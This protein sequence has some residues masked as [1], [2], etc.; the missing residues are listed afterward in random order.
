MANRIEITITAKKDANLRKIGQQVKEEVTAGAR[1]AGDAIE[2]EIGDGAR[3]AGKRAETELGDAGGRAGGR[4]SRSFSARSQL[5]DAR[6]RFAR[7]GAAAGGAMASAASRSFRSR[8]AGMFGRVGRRIGR[9]FGIHFG[10]AAGDAGQTAGR[11][12]VKGFANI[13][14]GGITSPMLLVPLL[15]AAAAAAPAAGA[16]LAAGVVFAFGA[17]LA[18]LGLVAAA[19]LKPVQKEIRRFKKFTINFLKDIGK[20]MASAFSSMLGNARRVLN[21]FRPL[22]KSTFKNIISPGLERF[23]TNLGTALTELKPAIKPLSK[24]FVDLLDAIGPQ[25]PELFKSIA[26]AI[27]KI[28]RIISQN[29][30]LFANIIIGIM[31]LIP[32]ALNLVGALAGAYVAISKFTNTKSFGKNLLDVLS[33]IN[34]LIDHLG[35]MKKVLKEVGGFFTGIGDKIGKFFKRFGDIKVP[36]GMSMMKMNIGVNDKASKVINRV[37]RNAVGF[38]K[39]VYRATMRGIDRATGLI[40]R[41]RKRAVRYAKATYRASMRA[42]NRA[43]GVISH[44]RKLARRYAHGTYRAVM[45]AANRAG[46]AIA[47]ARNAARRF[48]RGT[49]R[50]LLTARNAVWGAVRAALSAARQWA[51]RVFTAT[52]NVVKSFSPFEHGGVVGAKATGGVTAAGGI[53]RAATGGARGSSVLVGEHGPEIAELPGG[54]RVRSNPDTRRILGQSAGGGGGPIHIHLSI[55]GKDL[56]E[57]VIDPIRKTVASRGGNVQAVLGR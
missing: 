50:A 11:N 32:L 19:K 57:L 14:S 37:R 36:K 33:P 30:D 13:F 7:A 17:G 51:G 6:G 27:I 40:N 49:Y 43:G 3:D 55:A 26:D 9:T 46:G 1:G 47:S 54:S 45:R 8:A 10:S 15:A 23:F 2:K 53:A 28:S 31:E 41:V 12:A 56:G 22:L 24:A 21:E 48:A 18:G 5:G 4:F 35:G 52:L 38:A 29:P 16:A 25:L 39:G 42:V 20:P 44:A 34:A